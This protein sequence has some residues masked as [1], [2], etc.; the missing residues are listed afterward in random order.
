MGGV[1]DGP[2]SGAL[3]TS[4]LISKRGLLADDTDAAGVENLA[5]MLQ[6]AQLVMQ[7]GA[8]TKNEQHGAVQVSPAASCAILTASASEGGALATGRGWVIVTPAGR[9]N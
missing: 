3:H 1:V 6:I 7:R 2:P 4:R 5:A 9:A 8:Q